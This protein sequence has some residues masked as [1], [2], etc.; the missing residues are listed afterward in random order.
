MHG[1]WYRFRATVAEHYFLNVSGRAINS[2]YHSCYLDIA[3]VAGS[4]GVIII[5]RRDLN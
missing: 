2:I 5:F 3:W 4:L 1:S